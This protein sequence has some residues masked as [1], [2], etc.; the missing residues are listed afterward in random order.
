MSTSCVYAVLRHRWGA[1]ANEE[2]EHIAT[3]AALH[4]VNELTA[5]MKNQPDLLQRNVTAS[6]A[7]PWRQLRKHLEENKFIINTTCFLLLQH[8]VE[9][10]N[11]NKRTKQKAESD[12]RQKA[13]S[14]LIHHLC[15][16]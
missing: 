9:G 6:A 13:G 15:F 16:H 12:E 11:V 4:Q 3:P 8:S 1:N 14:L 2:G 7:S 10:V 5:G